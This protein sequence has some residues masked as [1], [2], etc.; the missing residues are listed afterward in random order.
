MS[1][2]Y[3]KLDPAHFYT[4]P[5]LSWDACL[6]MTEI[7]L[8]LISDGDMY[9]FIEKGLRGGLSVIT[10]RKGVANNKFM[11]SYDKKSKS[12]YISYFDANNLYGWATSQYRPYDGFK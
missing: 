4:S 3:Y 1:L 7:E 10:Q 6:K 12:K 9:L 11:N 2:E 5:G 8:E